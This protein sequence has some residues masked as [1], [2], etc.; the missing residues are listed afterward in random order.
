MTDLNEITMCIAKKLF[1]N[2]NWTQRSGWQNDA[3]AHMMNVSRMEMGLQP[4]I[5]EGN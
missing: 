5:P 2:W 3:W 1:P 4:I